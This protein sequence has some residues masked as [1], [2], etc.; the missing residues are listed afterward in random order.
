MTAPPAIPQLRPLAIGELLDVSIK[1]CLRHWKTL[2][3]IVLVV[4]VPVQLL[5]ILVLVST[6]PDSLRNESFLDAARARTRPTTGRR[7]PRIS[8]GRSSPG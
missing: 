4:T 2:L 6:A 3:K 8:A 5:S 1:I 7:A